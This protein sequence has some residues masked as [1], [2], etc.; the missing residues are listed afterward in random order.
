[1][2]GGQLKDGGPPHLHSHFP[3]HLGIRYVDVFSV[4]LILFFGYFK[5]IEPT[6]NAHL[7][8]YNLLPV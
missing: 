5:Y 3:P 1:M 8:T 4:Y 2:G 7:M 6:P